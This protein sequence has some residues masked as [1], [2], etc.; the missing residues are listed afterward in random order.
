MERPSAVTMT[1]LLL[2]LPSSLAKFCTETKLETTQVTEVMV[3][4]EVL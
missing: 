3:T 2:L 1:L 4:K